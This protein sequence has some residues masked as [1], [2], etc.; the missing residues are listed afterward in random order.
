MEAPRTSRDRRRSQRITLDGTVRLYARDGSW[1]T[2]I[3]DLSLRGVLVSHPDGCV[4]P[5]GTRFRMDLRIFDNVPVSMGA[6]LVRADERHMAFAWDRIDLDSFSRLK[7]LLELNLQQPELLY[8]ELGELG[9]A[10]APDKPQQG[11]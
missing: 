7:R 4:H 9:Q 8:R 3:I 2:T 10:Q 11:T 5:P 6:E 1:P